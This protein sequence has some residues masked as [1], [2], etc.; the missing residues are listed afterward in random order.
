MAAAGRQRKGSKSGHASRPTETGGHHRLRQL[1]CGSLV[2]GPL[3][4]GCVRCMEGG[5]LVLFI[6]GEC[7]FRCFY[8]PISSEKFGFDFS[9]ANERPV[10]RFE[11]VLEEARVMRANGTG[12]TGGD[13]LDKME[14]TLDWIRRLKKEFGEDHHIHLY[15]ATRVTPSQ[16]S[17]LAEAGLDELRIHVP[18]EWWARKDDYIGCLSGLDGIPMDIGVEMPAVPGRLAALEALLRSLPSPPVKFVNLNELE[19]SETNYDRMSVREHITKDDETHAAAESLETARAM[20]AKPWPFTLHFCTSVYKDAGQLKRRMLRRAEGV[21]SG[22]QLLTED[23]TLLFGVIEGPR[24]EIEDALHGLGVPPAEWAWDDGKGR[25]AIS[26]SRLERI[27]S[28]LPFPSFVV[29]EYP[30]WDR[31]EVEREPL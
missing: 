28:R 29:E 12:I 30:T 31:L 13:P 26:P 7:S 14:R 25:A 10:H 9:F 22:F 6:T 1:G 27:A 11:D 16:A 23:G 17:S 18:V 3:P 5:K 21:M 4:E 8:C 2:R 24:P 15:T 19:F 20:L